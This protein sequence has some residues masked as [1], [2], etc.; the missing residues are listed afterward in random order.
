MF[1]RFYEKIKRT[2]Y[3]ICLNLMAEDDYEEDFDRNYSKYMKYYRKRMYQK[4]K[5]EWHFNLVMLYYI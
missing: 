4:Q 3:N 2:I 1:K 5:E